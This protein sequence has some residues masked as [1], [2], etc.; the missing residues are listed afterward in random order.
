MDDLRNLTYKIEFDTDIKSLKDATKYENDIDKGLK[1]AA[2]SAENM[3][4][5]FKNAAKKAKDTAKNTDSIGTSAKTSEGS[6]KSLGKAIAGAYVTKKIVD[7]GKN[8]LKTFTDFE[9]SMAG[10]HA[11][12]G[13]ISKQDFES[14]KNAARSAGATTI[15]SAKESADA[16]NYL[17][18]A[19]YDTKTS[20]K[21]LPGVLNLAIAG[22]MDLARATD[23]A[24]DGLAAF[25]LGVEN[26]NKFNDEIAKTAQKSNTSVQQQAEA[27][28]QVAGTAK[29]AGFSLEEMNT[30]LGILAN[31]GKKGSEAGVALRNVILNLL[32]PQ[33]AEI[34]KDLQGY[35]FS[36][37][38]DKSTGKIK[39]FNSIVTSLNKTLNKFNPI[40]REAIKSQIAGKENI[41]AL[42]SLLEGNTKVLDGNTTEYK[43]L[44]D[45]INN[46]DG[47]A[48]EFADTQSKTV[49][50]AMKELNSAFEEMQISLFDTEGASQGIQDFLRWLASKLPKIGN[51]IQ[52]VS[53]IIMKIII[54]IEE[55]KDGIIAAIAGIGTALVTYKI[56]DTIKS[57]KKSM[58]SL[59]GTMSLF[60][61]PVFLAIA[62]I[63]L[64]V[65][66]FIYFY[67]TSEPFRKKVNEMT[68][69]I[70][71]LAEEFRENITP[72]IDFLSIKISDLWQWLEK[73]WSSIMEFVN[74]ISP[75]VM[76]I[77]ENLGILIQDFN[78][79]VIKPL[80]AIFLTVVW[81]AIK[82]VATWIG[83]TFGNTFELIGEV[84]GG[85]IEFLDGLIEFITGVFTNDWGKAWEGVKKMFGGI[86]DGIKGIARGVINSMIDGIN[87]FI[88]GINDLANI[89]MPD[90]LGGKQLELFTIPEIGHL[91]KF[92]RGTLNAPGG[93]SLVGENGPELMNVPSGSEVIPSN[94]TS[95][96]LNS[97]P[98]STI[99]NKFNFNITGTGN[100]RETAQI[101]KNSVR[102]EIED[103]FEMANI[104]LGY[105]DIESS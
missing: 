14:L 74:D 50:G 5:G 25:G 93:L 83:D 94:T 21:A 45:A 29:G 66:G 23:L 33:N 97:S 59:T 99:V 12:M 71:E 26:I 76:S 35:G 15:F 56:L 58:A 36:G 27:I 11:T 1:K 64:L 85:I 3:G 28:L 40:Q 10:V 102:K 98:S 80:A 62:A 16:L 54:F 69:A 61:N 55:H 105:V 86:W 7:F 72:A 101:I 49:K 47:T 30:Q 77:I 39:N 96:I 24:T 103:I 104:Q 17:A 88:R 6:V 32:S 4:S 89:K 2:Q 73:I 46:A 43:K 48:Q 68:D 19:G 18:L 92:A 52:Y 34:L 57:I 84:I 81:P 90:W 37:V 31:R 44:F 67:E 65:G 75:N 95:R 82:N 8:A 91:E 13:N 38:A 100:A 41:Q 60:S 9:Q 20:I 87:F 22:N 53:K 78:E 63:A 51:E 70:A 79:D 42:N